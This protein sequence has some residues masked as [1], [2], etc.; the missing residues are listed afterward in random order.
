MVKK[1]F[2]TRFGPINEIIKNKSLFLMILPAVLYYFLFSYLPM[3]GVI[4]AFKRY[5]Y[6]GGIFNSPWVGL[7][8]FE[9]LFVTG[10]IYSVAFNTIAY[11]VAFISVGVVLQLAFAVFLSEIG[12]RVFRKITQSVIFLPYFIS[13]VIVGS[14]LHANVFQYE[15]GSLNGL[16]AS[17]G[18]APVDVYS[19]PGIWKYILV[20]VNVWKWT[21]YCT[22][23]YLAAIMGID[24]QILE[25]AEIDGAGKLG[26]IRRIVLPMILPQ[27]VILLLLSIGNI[28]RGDFSM[29]Y[30][31]TANNP[32]VYDTTDVIDT[33]VVRSLLQIQDIGMSSAVG[34][35]Q[36]VICFFVLMFSNGLIKKYQKEYALF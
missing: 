21:G 24:N 4:L 32:R 36:S 20:A 6:L 31:V 8:N 35:M 5:D 13:W 22:V 3:V 29:F 11:N 15:F 2:Q 17:L 25:A 19:N 23:V 12:S 10:K 9:F 16:L 1:R 28:F 7:K 18:L 26:K 30:Q 34:L 33:F 27:I 14:F